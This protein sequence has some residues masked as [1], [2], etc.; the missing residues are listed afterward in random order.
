MEQEQEKLPTDCQESEKPKTDIW[1]NYGPIDS[2]KRGLNII[3][4]ERGVGKTYGAKRKILKKYIE[5]GAQAV[6]IRRKDAEIKLTKE[7]FMG[8][9]GNDPLFKD[10]IFYTEGYI[11]YEKITEGRKSISKPV[12]Y[13][14]P[15]STY[16]HY[17]SSS[18]EKVETLVFDE[19]LTK[20]R[21]LPDEVFKFF[22][23]SETVFRHR[24]GKMYLLGNSLSTINPYFEHFN[25][26]LSESR[27]TKSQQ[28]VVENCN[29]VEFRKFKKTTFIGELT[30]GSDYSQYAQENKFVLDDYTAVEEYKGE[31]QFR[32]NLCL[33][34]VHMG[35]YD[36]HNAMYV[37]EPLDGRTFTIY[38]DDC[39]DNGAYILDKKSPYLQRVY[40]KFLK[41]IILYKN[42]SYKNEIVLM[43]RKIGRNF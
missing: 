10:R 6:W 16:E 22:D 14:I 2:Y 28:W 24:S 5:T 12:I 32:Y 15:L 39:K 30:E 38:L 11:L 13:F 19:F 21:Y 20:E 33:N 3:V 37:G 8:D 29:N 7:R 17:K 36:I 31:R 34:G 40:M 9:I 42:L 1:Y 26:K 27:F 18:Y 43:C 4:G 35:I 41:G 23:I 25:I